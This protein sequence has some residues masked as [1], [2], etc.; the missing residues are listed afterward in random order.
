MNETDRSVREEFRLL[1]ERA[2]LTVSEAQRDSLLSTYAD[3]KKQLALLHRRPGA[4]PSLVF[5]VPA[6]PST[7]PRTRS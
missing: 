3:L 5:H 4:E 1:I 6:P 2:G 7:P